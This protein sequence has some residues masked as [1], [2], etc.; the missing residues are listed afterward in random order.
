MDAD[1]TGESTGHPRRYSLEWS[2]A[3]SPEG[4]RVLARMADLASR[5][6]RTLCRLVRTH[7]GLL[8][9]TG[10]VLLV[11]TLIIGIFTP[12]IMR[13]CLLGDYPIHA[14]LAVDM[15]H[16]HN[17]MI[18][19]FLYHLLLMTA[20]GI[21]VF[22]KPLTADPREVAKY[23]QYAWSLPDAC[24]LVITTM[25]V[26]QGVILYRV[27]RQA[28]DTVAAWAASGLAVLLTL[29]L[30]VITAISY[31]LPL[32]HQHYLG[33]I[34]A[35]VYHNPTV[36]VLKPLALLLFM[37]MVQLLRQSSPVRPAQVVWLWLLTIVSTLAKPS[38]AICLFPVVIL[39]L[40]DLLRKRQEAKVKAL[41]AGF[42]LPMILLLCWQYLVTFSGNGADGGGG[43]RW[44][45]L[46]L[47]AVSGD[48]LPK[49]LL[50]VL[51]PLCVY[52]AF[53]SAA[54]RDVALNLSWMVFGVSA[55]YMYGFVESGARMMHF[56]LGWGA[57]VS[58]FL[59]YV[60]SVVFLIRQRAG[61]EAPAPLLRFRPLLC[62]LVFALHVYSGVCWWWV[63]YVQMRWGV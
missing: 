60:S 63:E 54:R 37:Q 21:L 50:S 27:V 24:V 18:S 36:V 17:R 19:Y 35:T 59:L 7:I 28:L 11:S 47:H 5:G 55:V 3:L 46:M 58:L 20:H 40:I 56:N 26:V 45:P 2:S 31:L 34:T 39:I 25:V 62:W 44:A 15:F 10:A 23:A 57:Q 38:Y 42:V 30:M 33:Y 4:A 29:A 13:W 49:F 1:H 14:G 43:F 52:A 22:V 12:S 16:R 53:F 61:R 9:E 32:D 48:L 6:K 41:L 8:R 51:F